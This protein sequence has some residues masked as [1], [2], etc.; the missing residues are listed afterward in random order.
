MFSPSILNPGWLSM[1]RLRRA[2][3]VSTLLLPAAIGGFVVQER[4]S[5]DGARVF[6]QVMSLVSDRFVDTVDAATLYEKAARGLVQQLN[7]PYSE[8]FSPKQLKR[9]ATQSTGRYG[10]IGMQIENQ[11]GNITIVRVF[12]HTPAEAAGVLEGDRIIGIDTMSTRGWTSQH[13]SDVLVGTIGTKVTVR[14][15]RP[16][17]TQPIEHTFARAEIH[18][19]AVPY[20]MMLDNR[21]A[22][23]PL[24]TFNETAADELQG[25]VNRLLKQ[26]AKGIILD[27][28]SN[29]GGILDQ[30]LSVA[31]LFLPPGKQI[32][33]VRTRQGPPQAFVSHGAEHIA[34]V[35]LVALVDGYSASASEIVAGALQDHDR[36]LVVGTTSYGKGLVQT[37]YPLDGGWAL[38]MTTGKWFTPSGRS[39]QKDRKKASPEEI[40]ER[41]LPVTPEENPPD[42][43]EKE[44][45]KKNRP[46]F[47]S[48]AGRLLYGCALELKGKVTPDFVVKPEWREELYRR[49]TQAKVTVDKKQYDAAAPMVNRWISQQVARLAFGDST[50]FRRQIPDD[51]Q[52]TRALELLKKGQTQ[53]DLF[54]LAQASPPS[55]R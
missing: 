33:S 35:P 32:A 8:L 15:A 4:A 17:V 27:L 6:D 38:K 53:K 45:V 31:D 11:E 37:V 23:V 41:G 49:L 20:A 39:I 40:A 54:A 9:F 51:P 18:V 12:P 47:R 19:P 14:F 30:G 24:Q 29:P 36:A 13:V 25:A 7:D 55:N 42:S 5:R 43:L 44:S 26:G 52:M 10:G 2:V 50:A 3:L 21:I 46:A 16:G 1:P 34:D 22:Y 48:D 28:R